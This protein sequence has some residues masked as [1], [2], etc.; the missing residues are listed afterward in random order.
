MMEE[1]TTQMRLCPHCANS[2]DADAATC[3]Y[4]KADLLF[5]IIPKWLYR[6]ERSS[7]RRV[8]VNGKKKF[9]ISWKFICSVAMLTV[10]LLAFMAGVYLQRSELLLLSQ[11]NLNRLQA[12]DQVIQSQQT[13]L[14]QVQQ[15]LSESSKQLDEMMRKL[16]ESQKTLLA[17]Q[18]RLGVTTREAGRL[19]ATR[20][21]AVRRSTS[22]APDTARSFPASSVRRTTD[23][24]VFE[25]I[26]ATAVYENP[27]SASRVISQIG[28]GTRINVVNSAGDWLEVRSKHGNPPGYVRADDARQLGRAN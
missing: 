10:V 17:T 8:D 5:G 9:P 3:S 23:P 13:Q 27:S 14:A 28:R 7:E 11:A 25:T 19:N 2:I 21:V 18:Q 24:G 1:T 12:K 20:S 6:K 16:Q 22:R 15:Q 26:Q 4:C